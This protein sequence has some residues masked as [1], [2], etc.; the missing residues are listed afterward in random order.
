MISRILIAF[1]GSEI[2]QRALDY[3]VKF[4]ECWGAELTILVVVPR[5]MMPLP[6]RAYL[7]GFGR[8]HV[9]S[10]RKLSQDQEKMRTAY[11]KILTEVEERVRLEH[12]RLKAMLRLEEG[13]PSSTIVDIAEDEGFD[14]VVIGSRGLGYLR[15]LILCSTSNHVTKSCSKPVLI[16]KHH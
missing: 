13:P 5:V 12:P 2:S 15:A 16:V 9:N 4:A 7:N 11:Q 10:T 1:D 6:L 14:I 8:M 3:A